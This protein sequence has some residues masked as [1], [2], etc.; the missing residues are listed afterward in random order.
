MKINDFSGPNP[1]KSS[2][3]Q[4]QKLTKY[5]KIAVKKSRSNFDDQKYAP[6]RSWN[7]TWGPKRRMIHI[8]AP[9]ADLIFGALGPPK[10]N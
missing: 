8:G 7:A 9:T 4:S 1:P 3:K 6:R 10:V 2:P 5:N